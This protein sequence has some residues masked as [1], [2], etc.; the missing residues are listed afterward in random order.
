VPRRGGL[1]DWQGAKF[2]RF[3]DNMR[4]VAVTEGD[5]VAAQIQ[6]GYA[7]TATAWATWSRG[8]AP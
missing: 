8:C 6:F 3:G 4:E 1:G 2:C 5:K 7:V